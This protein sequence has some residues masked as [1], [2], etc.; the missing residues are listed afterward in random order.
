[1]RS[2][3]YNLCVTYSNM[4]E[5]LK[6]IRKKE[7]AEEL[8]KSHSLS[9]TLLKELF[10]YSMKG[11]NNAEIAQKI[12]VHRVTIQRYSSTLKKMK[13]SDFK[14]IYKYVLNEVKNDKILNDNLYL[15]E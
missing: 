13:E 10:I 3:K 7:T 2:F 11:F 12:G 9:L 14:K 1:M 4:E 8:C 6:E 5:M 15:L